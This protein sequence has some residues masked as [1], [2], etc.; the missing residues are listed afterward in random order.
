MSDPF[1][2]YQAWLKIRPEEDR[3]HYRL[4]GI[5]LFEESPEVIATAAD[6]R[7]ACVEKSLGGEH[8]EL[9]RQILD[10][11]AAA[12]AC[13]LA[14]EEKAVYDEGIRRELAPSGGKAH[15]SL[16][17]MLLPVGL[18][19]ILV[20]GL[21]LWGSRW[22]G[23]SR[24]AGPAAIE[25]KTAAATQPALPGAT[26][27]AASG[28]VSP[29]P[30]RRREPSQ[31]P[32]A[33]L[34]STTQPAVRAPPVS[35]PSQAALPLQAASVA[36]Q[37]GGGSLVNSIG[38]R[39]AWVPAGEFAMGSPGSDLAAEPHEQPRHPVRI[40]KPFYLG[41]YEVTQAE[42]AEV[43]GTNPSWFDPSSG[44]RG[45]ASGQSGRRP[46]ERVSWEDAQA[47]CRRLS[48]RPEER[49]ACRVYRLPTEAEW[50]YACRAGGTGRFGFGGDEAAILD[51][52]WVEGNSAAATHPV[53]Q[54]RPN[55][56]G[57]YDMHG[58]VWEWCGDWYEP[59][60]YGQSP[61]ENPGGP[62]SGSARVVRG[63]SFV[64]AAATCRSAARNFLE[65][66]F[67]E[68]N[69]IGFRVVCE[70][71]GGRAGGFR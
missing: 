68:S 26:L 8:G 64:N 17:A 59:G 9:A 35:P 40:T 29:S 21:V 56:W 33:A 7:M 16:A 48:E 39:L 18:G 23:L 41:L 67:Q 3:N 38:M 54:K 13:L 11:L 50:E 63:G 58:N 36:P 1:D 55:A 20:F 5:R 43:M 57:L 14:P 65:P 12:K 25:A 22:S 52:A 66:S 10:Q 70:A 34:V 30:E 51:H 32:P 37:S 44:A 31:S 6:K 4:L 45:T 24:G 27:P 53:G 62:V 60:Y 19:V 69:G 49:A 2:P 46:V 15:P 61:V 47:F 42:Y 71:A 28:P